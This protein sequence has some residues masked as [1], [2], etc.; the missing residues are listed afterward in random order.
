MKR[1]ELLIAALLCLI[2]VNL[3]FT[4]FFV[5]TALETKTQSETNFR[6]IQVIAGFLQENANRSGEE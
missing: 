3:G 5:L 1:D 2:V 6:N 4:A